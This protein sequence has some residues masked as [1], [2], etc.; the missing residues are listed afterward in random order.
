MYLMW[1][2]DHMKKMTFNIQ[3]DLLEDA[4]KATGMKEKTA[5]IHYGLKELIRKNAIKR[6]VERA[7]TDPKASV[8]PRKRPRSP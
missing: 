7:G 4:S 3:E 8:F 6:L 5:L 1:Y 2:N